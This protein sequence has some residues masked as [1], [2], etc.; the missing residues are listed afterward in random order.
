M[1]PRLMT[2]RLILRGFEEGDLDGMAEMM[3]DPEVA[4]FIAPAPLTREQSWRSMAG[5]LG[6]WHLRGYG[7]WAVLRA[8]DGAFVG[9]VGLVNPEGWPGL[10]VGWSLTRACWGKGYATEA[11][12]AA[13][14]YAFLTLRPDRLISSIDAANFASQRV[15]ER[16]GESR[17]PSQT[18]T[19]QGERFE[20]DIWSIDRNAWRARRPIGSAAR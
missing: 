18:I 14:D 12:E 9:R 4:R 3:A 5:M 10:E 16:L 2:E 19:S 17:G 20:V 13:M 15:A 8:S 1:I 7:M 6:H 11:A